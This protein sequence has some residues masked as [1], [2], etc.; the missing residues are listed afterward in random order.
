MIRI[1]LHVE[2]YD[3]ENWLDNP[4]NDGN[5]KALARNLTFYFEH[6]ALI[7]DI[8]ALTIEKLS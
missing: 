5:E 4:F 7:G 6:D 8:T 1:I 2:P 3:E